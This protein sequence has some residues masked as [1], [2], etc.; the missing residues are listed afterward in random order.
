MLPLNWEWKRIGPKKSQLSIKPKFS[1]FDGIKQQKHLKVLKHTPYTT[2]KPHGNT[3]NLIECT[4]IFLAFTFPKFFVTVMNYIIFY[5][6][7]KK[8]ITYFKKMFEMYNLVE[9]L[10]DISFKNSSKFLPFYIVILF[11]GINEP[12]P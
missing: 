3:V 4:G 7:I 6:L 8:F 10:C 11:Y 1:C 5:L 9:R 2:H 12:G